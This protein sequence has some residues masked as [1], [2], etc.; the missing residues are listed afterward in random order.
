MNTLL[1]LTLG[2]LL[3]CPILA[4]AQTSTNADPSSPP[5]GGGQGGRLA[6]YLTNAEKAEMRAA[7]K[8]VAATNPDPGGAA[9]GCDQAKE[10]RS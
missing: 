2:A 3:A 6:D 1:Y 9:D 4:H 7:A 8:A 10:S 5:H